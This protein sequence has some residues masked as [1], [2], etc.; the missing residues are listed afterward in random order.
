MEHQGRGEEEGESRIEQWDG[1]EWARDRERRW[2]GVTW[3]EGRRIRRRKRGGRPKTQE[4]RARE[5]MMKA[6]GKTKMMVIDVDGDNPKGGRAAERGG[7]L[8]SRGEKQ[9]R[10][11][12]CAR[13]GA[14]GRV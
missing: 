13:R 11:E 3:E 9:Q 1:I 2:R 8:R 6:K 7:D 12:R 10:R 4:H 14:G 5:R